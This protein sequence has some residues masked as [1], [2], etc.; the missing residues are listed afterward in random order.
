MIH[1]FK[2]ENTPQFLKLKYNIAAIRKNRPDDGSKHA[3]RWLRLLKE[4]GYCYD[5]R[6]FKVFLKISYNS[7]VVSD[8]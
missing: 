6:K 2:G 3:K 7:K 8:N 5:K 1:H 4:G